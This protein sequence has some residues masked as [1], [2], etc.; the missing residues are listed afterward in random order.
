MGCLSWKIFI[1]CVSFGKMGVILGMKGN[2]FNLKGIILRLCKIKSLY[3][4]LND[5]TEVT[6]SE[7]WLPNLNLYLQKCIKYY[8]KRKIDF[9]LAIWYFK[10]LSN[11]LLVV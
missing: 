11:R 4:S 9:H 1:V 5:H 6:E 8:S 7:I 2:L 3:L 10:I